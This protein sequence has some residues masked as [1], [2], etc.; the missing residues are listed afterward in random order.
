MIQL[1]LDIGI[2]LFRYIFFFQAEDGI[3]DRKR[4]RLN[5]SHLAISY[6]VFCLK[7]KMLSAQDERELTGLQD[8]KVSATKGQNGVREMDAWCH[9]ASVAR[10]RETR[11]VHAA[12]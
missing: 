7:K 12:G 8:S 11:C 10:T 9:H 4:T 2:A 1:Q 6:A 3:R 5:S